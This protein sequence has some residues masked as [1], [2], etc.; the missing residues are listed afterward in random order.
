MKSKASL[1]SH[2]IHPMLVPFP[3][4]FFTG[5][6]VLDLIALITSDGVY[7]Q[8]AIFLQTGGIIM[9]VVAAIPGVIDYIFSVPPASSAKKRATEHALLNMSMLLFFTIA[10]LLKIYSGASFFIILALE[11]AGT[12]LLTMAGWLGGTLVH[13]N[14]IG[15][16]HRYAHAGKWSEEKLAASSGKIEVRGLSEMKTNQM[17][18][19]HAGSRRIAIARTGKGFVAF[20]DR[21]THRGASLADGAMICETV[22]CPWHGSQFEVNEG[23]VQAGPAK[24]QIR[25]YTL[26]QEGE[27]F[28]LEL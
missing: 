16:D 8:A 11:L 3:I 27:K 23:A 9:A 20:D 17:K 22:Q 5:T 18:L 21:C 2:P 15:V 1:K 25:T 13:R 24:E 14:Q 26:K 12:V 7:A 6:F 10:L 4:A 19:V 28:F